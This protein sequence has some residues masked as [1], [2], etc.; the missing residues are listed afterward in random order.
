MLSYGGKERWNLGGSFKAWRLLIM[1]PFPT[2]RHTLR[3]TPHPQPGSN[4]GG[5]EISAPFQICP[6]A[7]PASCTM[8]T[9]YFLGVK[10]PGHGGDHPPPSSAEV[11][12]E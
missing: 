11:K 12:E 3:H 8:G 10:L 7:Q 1:T 5:G 4:S 9:W 6:G 2:L